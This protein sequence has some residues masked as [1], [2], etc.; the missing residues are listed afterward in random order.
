MK[1]YR[2]GG[3]VY[4]H[5]LDGAGAAIRGARWN[6]PTVP[7]IY[8]AG[9]RA[10]ALL[11]VLAH[12]ADHRVLPDD[13]VVVTYELMG[14]KGVR[15]PARRALPAGWDRKGPPY[16]RAAQAYGA[17][18]IAS[19]NVALRVPSAIVPTE[20]NYL[21]NPRTLSGRVRIVSVEP[22]V[23]DARISALLRKR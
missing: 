9:S 1:L 18:F 6:P 10:L 12:F 5:R 4:A 8:T 13:T 3:A 14:R 17:A 20:W 2:L 7:M 21:L 19:P 15:Y 22:F 23:L 11:E 16:S